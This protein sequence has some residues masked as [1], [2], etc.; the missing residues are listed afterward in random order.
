MLDDE[1]FSD[2]DKY[3]KLAEAYARSAQ[4]YTC[5]GM[6]ETAAEFVQWSIDFWRKANHED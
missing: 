4:F 5:C 6:W 3:K 1:V 2:K